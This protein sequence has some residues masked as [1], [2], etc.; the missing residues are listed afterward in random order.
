[1][2]LL[3]PSVRFCATLAMTVKRIGQMQERSS[4]GFPGVKVLMPM[5]L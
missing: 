4:I 5:V 1:V 2:R 3:P